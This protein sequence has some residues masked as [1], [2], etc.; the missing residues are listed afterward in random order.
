MKERLNLH[1]VTMDD[2]KIIF[3]WANDPEIR[4]NSFNTADISWP[5]HTTWMEHVLED[6]HILFFLLVDNDKPV[7]QIRLAFNDGKWEISYSI[8]PAYRGQGYGKII[9]QLAENE[10]IRGGHAGERLYAEVKK[11][12][13]ASQRIFK[14]LGY[15]EAVSLHVNAYAYTK[16]VA[17][18]QTNGIE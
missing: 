18:E 12:N 2:A 5:E 3:D 4:Q 16:D 8:A 13:I 15:G 9:L 1:L 6:E 10:L 17:K 14:K 11:D 7:G